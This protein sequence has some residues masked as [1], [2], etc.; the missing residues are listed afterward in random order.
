MDSGGR[1]GAF[2]LLIMNLNLGKR[3]Q[4]ERGEHRLHYISFLLHEV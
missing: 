4:M 1:Q 3:E 2:I